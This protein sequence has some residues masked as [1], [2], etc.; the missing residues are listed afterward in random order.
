[1][2]DMPCHDKLPS[3]KKRPMC[4]QLT[5]CDRFE[6][7]IK[8]A[9]PPLFQADPFPCSVSSLRR[10][11]LFKALEDRGYPRSPMA[12]QNLEWT[13]SQGSSESSTLRS[14]YPKVLNTH[15]HVTGRRGPTQYYKGMGFLFKG[16]R[17]QVRFLWVRE[18]PR[19]VIN[20]GNREI[21]KSVK[22]T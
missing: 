18:R 5:H 17:G 20:F 16:R 4:Y 14:R 9:V 21:W 7:E 11:R 22:W 12:T 8:P 15:T 2:L 13:G 6:P 1:M 10:T 3:P 19:N